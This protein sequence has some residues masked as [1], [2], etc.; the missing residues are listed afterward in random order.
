MRLH[1]QSGFT[2]I[3]LM[4]SMTLGLSIAFFAID[5]A[6]NG[7]RHKASIL[8]NSEMMETGRYLTDLLRSEVSHAGFFGNVSV[9]ETS[10]L[11]S[12]RMC[13]PT[14]HIDD[15]LFP[16][17]GGP[18]VPCT[19]ISDALADSDILMIRRAETVTAPSASANEY[20]IQ[21]NYAGAI[22]NTA[23]FNLLDSF[24]VLADLYPYRQ[25]IYYVDINKTFNR[26]S[27]SGGTYTK[28]FLASGVDDFVVLYGL[29][30]G[31][32][33][34]M[35]AYNDL[36][37]TRDGV[38]NDWKS[39]ANVS[40]WTEV[41]AVKFFLLVRSTGTTGRQDQKKYTYPGYTSREFYDSYQRHLFTSVAVLA[42]NKPKEA[43]TD[44]TVV[45]PSCGSCYNGTLSNV[46]GGWR[47]GSPE[48]YQD[49]CITQHTRWPNHPHVNNVTLTVF[50]NVQIGNCGGKFS[51]LPGTIRYTGTLY[52][53]PHHEQLPI[54]LVRCAGVPGSPGPGNRYSP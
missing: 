9:I 24:G 22:L 2:L 13:P 37:H 47:P 42:N 14:P 46:P 15:L 18:E 20:Y 39:A 6:L 45:I 53:C 19:G 31:E 28:E 41:I 54:K 27:F 32:T 3:E 30:Y 49:K 8:A 10:S 34:T 51:R 38:V 25:D 7:Q 21:A 44:P 29:D 17:L 33:H 23:G 1:R 35:N 48:Y 43:P 40:D 50:G 36:R 26:Y 16:I 5:I 12:E 4:V 52:G 11:P